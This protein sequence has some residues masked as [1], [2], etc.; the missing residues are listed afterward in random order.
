MSGGAIIRRLFYEELLKKEYTNLIPVA[1]LYSILNEEGIT[2][3]GQIKEEDL[4]SL[5]N[6]LDADGISTVTLIE[7]EYN[8]MQIGAEKDE[9]KPNRRCFWNNYRP[10]RKP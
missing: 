8:T 5:M 3:G 1:A 2:E 4:P 6:K 10:G 9:L 7:R